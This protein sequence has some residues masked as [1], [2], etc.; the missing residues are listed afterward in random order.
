[1]IVINEWLPDPA[2]SDAAGEWIEL[3][4]SGPGPVSLSGWQLKTFGSGRYV[5]GGEIRGGE[6]R[7]LPRSETKLVLRNSDGSIFLYGSDGKLAHQAAFLGE[8]PEGKSV[9]VR[10]EGFLFTRPTP[11]E[12][13]QLSGELALIDQAHPIGQPLHESSSPLAVSALAIGVA[14]AI[15]TAVIILVKSNE[16]LSHAFFGRN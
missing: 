14:I 9:A 5:L 12:A 11:G 4:N 6:Y 7:I 2:G 10:G 16:K 3:W 1:M 15:A 8:A 13:N